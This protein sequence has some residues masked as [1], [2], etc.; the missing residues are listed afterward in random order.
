MPMMLA[1]RNKMTM[2]CNSLLRVRGN[3]LYELENVTCRKV[4]LL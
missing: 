2:E 4:Q 3:G 1:G